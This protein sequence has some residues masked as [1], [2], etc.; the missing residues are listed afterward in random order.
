MS[1]RPSPYDAGLGPVSNSSRKLNSSRRRKS[2]HRR[3]GEGI[4]L[5]ETIEWFVPDVK[6]PSPNEVVLL[7]IDNANGDRQ[8]VAGILLETGA[9][10][11]AIGHQ[12]TALLWARWPEGPQT[13]N[14]VEE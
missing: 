13:C 14:D 2:L 3:P 10:Q 7:C 5:R 12:V 1:E 8:I 11:N 9:Y 6:N 4:H